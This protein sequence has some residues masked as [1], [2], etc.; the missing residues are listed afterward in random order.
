MSRV[1]IYDTT[2]RDGTQAEDFNLLLEDKLRIA[3]KLDELGVHYIE[4]G[5]PGS[6]PKDAHFFT[7][8][9]RYHLKNALIAAFGSTHHPKN[10][11]E[12]DP[13]L[14]ALME[15]GTEVVTI[16]GKTWDLHVRD[17]LKVSPERNLEII[18][19]SVAYLRP[20]VKKLFY[21][22]EHFFDG[23]KDNPE[24][25][26]ATITKAIEAGADCIIFCDT[27][28]GTLPFELAEIV[29]AIKEKFPDISWGIHA[30]NDAECAVANSLMAVHLGATQVQGTLNGVGE[31]CGN[32]NLCSIIPALKLKMGVD[33]VS[34]E[35]LARLTGVSR[36]VTEL[37]NIPH[38]QYLP[39]VG[40][41]AFA[42]KGGVHVSAV[43]RNPRTY[44]HIP[45]ERVGNARRILI[46][47]LSGKSTILSKA[48]QW[49]IDLDSKDPEV[50]KILSELKELEN[51]GFQFDVAE[52]SFK[53]RMYRARGELKKDYFKLLTYRVHDYNTF[54][55]LP[56]AEAETWIE[57]KG[58]ER[59]AISLGQGPV[60]ALDKALRKALEE[61]YPYLREMTLVDYRVRVLP[62]TS[63]TEAK[64]RVLIESKDKECVWRTVGVSHDILAASL[65]ALIDSIVYKLFRDEH[66]RGEC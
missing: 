32:T 26:L 14:K 1:E 37:L 55:G 59:H 60:N 41:S 20:H 64:I 35:Q 27:N 48:R 46:S 7:E 38:P 18:Y 15:A 57:V 43:Q 17:A 21:D 29:R 13:N 19:N 61:F 49:G 52:E 62:G 9:K 2:L 5:W 36:Y 16:F 31:R 28:G 50:Q 56:I 45:P 39:Y 4:G 10:Q 44:E 58:E 6:N 34:D 40:R 33:C 66:K 51:Q 42:H 23:F 12:N 25:A 53:L 65:Q 22:A 54:A 11:P 30:H 8:I 3:Q 63:G 24:Y 47:D